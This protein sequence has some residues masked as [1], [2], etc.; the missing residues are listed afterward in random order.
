MSE[1]DR[2]TEGWAVRI[3]EGRGDRIVRTESKTNDH[4]NVGSYRFG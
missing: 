4:G 3:K 1:G 2:E